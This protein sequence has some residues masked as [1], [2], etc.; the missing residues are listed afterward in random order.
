MVCLLEYIWIGGLGELRSKTKV[1]YDSIDDLKS[2]PVWN[3]DGS[4]TAQALNNGTDT[5]ITLIPVKA[6]PDPFRR[7]GSGIALTGINVI[8]VSVPLFR[9]YINSS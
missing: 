6:I 3:F 1:I 8:S 9:D 4:S 2:I 7:N 5:E